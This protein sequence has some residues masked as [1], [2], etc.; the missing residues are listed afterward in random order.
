MKSKFYKIL[1]ICLSSVFV[2]LG[3]ASA[4]AYY[5]HGWHHGGYY[6]HGWYPHHY[7]YYGYGYRHCGWVPG[8]WRHGYWVPGHRV[9]WR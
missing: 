3:S 7:Y 4:S 6:H 1:L 5:H 8:H 2:V 9:C